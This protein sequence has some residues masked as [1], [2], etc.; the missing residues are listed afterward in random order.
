MSPEKKATLHLVYVHGFQ[1]DHTSFQAFPTDLH[2]NLLKKLPEYISLDSC[3]YPTYK[4]R[5]HIS[6]VALNFLR[7]LNTLDP[8]PVILLAHSMGGLL[9]V[10]AATTPKPQS[11]RIKAIVAF[12]VP[13]LSMHPHVVISG[14]A[15]LFPKDD[16]K[17]KTEKELNDK[18]RVNFVDRSVLGDDHL[19]PL[20]S[21]SGTPRSDD[22]SS[23]TSRTSSSPSLSPTSS[24]RNPLDMLDKVSAFVTKHADEP[25]IK[26]LRKHSDEPFSAMRS[27]VVEHFQFG[28]CMFDPVGLRDRYRALETWN[29]LWVNY[30]TETVPKPGVPPPT[31]AS[32]ENEDAALEL[33]TAE[34][35]GLSSELGDEAA[36]LTKETEMARTKQLQ[37]AEKELKKQRERERKAM[38][39]RPAR[40][41]IVLP[42]A[43][44]GKARHKWLKVPIA[45]AED[46]VQAHCG[47][48]IRGT[49]LEYDS[50]VDR[51]GDLLKSWY[52]LID[53]SD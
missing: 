38:E 48:F 21:P 45:G 1:G 51:V 44:N 23:L 43:F 19:S 31:E 47:L 18:D 2:N 34:I 32:K 20:P 10:E 37:K 28:Q 5:K 42:G 6:Y 4:S 49:N 9:A 50:F 13:Y 26:F 36:P 40:H 3:L 12:D 8:G 15:S 29:G 11:K 39:P 16:E 53:F 27:W 14:I 7:W 30:W 17:H 25:M 52:P 46:E 22:T 24:S 41:F 35:G 33:T